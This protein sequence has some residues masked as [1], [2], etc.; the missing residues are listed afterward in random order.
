M[1]LEV[2]SVLDVPCFREF[3]FSETPEEK[4]TDKPNGHNG[5]KLAVSA[6]SAKLHTPVKAVRSL[7]AN[8][9]R[10]QG[11]IPLRHNTGESPETVITGIRRRARR[12]IGRDRTPAPT[13]FKQAVLVCDISEEP[14]FTKGT[15][16]TVISQDNEAGNCTVYFGGTYCTVPLVSNPITLALYS[17]L[18]GFC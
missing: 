3:L 2:P 10:T 6:T 15:A 17:P 11:S 16:V 1:V 7:S 13:S 14:T 4:S 8:Q 18:S 12:S 9:S 5:V